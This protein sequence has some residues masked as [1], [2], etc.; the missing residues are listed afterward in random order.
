[1][2]GFQ[3]SFYGRVPTILNRMLDSDFLRKRWPKSRLWGTAPLYEEG[4]EA[5]EVEAISGAC[6]MVHQPNFLN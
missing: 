4:K 1:M 5:R 2:T 6:L 3:N